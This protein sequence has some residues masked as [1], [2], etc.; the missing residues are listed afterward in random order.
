M[1]IGKPKL[2]TKFEVASP[3]CCRNINGQPPNFGDS[4]AQGTPTFFWCDLMMGLGKPQLHA[5]FQVPGFICYGNAREFVFKRQIRFLEP[6]FW[7]S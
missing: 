3:S 4:L 5:K 7:G 2:Y 1:G 6:P